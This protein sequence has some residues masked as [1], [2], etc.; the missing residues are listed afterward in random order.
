MAI[1]SR[2]LSACLT[3][4]AGVA[5]GAPMT[6]PPLP[7]GAY[8]EWGTP[9]AWRKTSSQRDQVCLNG[10]W[11][12]RSEPRLA[13]VEVVDTFFTD[14]F[15]NSVPNDWDVAE[16]PGGSL[17]ACPDSV[18]KC[19]GNTS[20]RVEFD[21]P[22]STNFYHITRF[23][24]GIPTGIKLVLRVDVWAELEYGDLHM[25]V[26][27]A[28]GYQLYTARGGAFGSTGGWKTMECEFILPADTDTIKILILRN[29]GS[30]SGC[31]GVVWIDNLRIVK[32]EHPASPGIAPPTDDA[33]GFAKVPGSWKG[34]TYWHVTDRARTN[35]G[36]LRFAWFERKVEVP[37]GWN[38]RKIEVQFERISTDARIYVNGV[39]T[40]ALGYTGGRVDITPRVKPGETFTLSVLVEAR[41]SWVILPTLLTR[42]AKAWQ[43]VLSMTGIVGDAFLCSEPA[44][45]RPRIG[46][47]RI[48][49]SANKGI[50][51]VDVALP[52]PPGAVL[53]DDLTLRCEVRDKGTVVRTFEMAVPANS[54][55]VTCSAPWP[56][57]EKWDIG[58]PRL[59]DLTVS[60]FRNGRVIDE[61]LPIRFGFREFEIRDRFFYLNGVRL[62]LVPCSYWA[63]KGN[64]G[65][66]EAMR[67]WL[68][69]ARNAGYNFV[70]LGETDRPGKPEVASHFLEICDE[71]GIL[72]SVSPLGISHSIYP[73]IEQDEVWGPWTEIVSGRIHRSW[74]HP[75]L[76]MWRMNM[77]LNCYAQ[78]QNPLVLD[79]Q[80]DFL[81]DSASARKEAAMLKSNAF[82]QSLDPTRPT[83]NH[84]CGKTGS[85][86]NLNNYLGW[87]ELQDLR[88]WLRVWA[89]Q[90][91]KPLMMAEQA[92]PYPGDFQMRDPSNWWTNEP[93][94]TEYGAILLG[95]R[96]YVLEEEDYVDYEARCWNA[97]QKKWGSSYGYF[98]FNFPPIL[99]ECSARYYEAMLPAWRT[100]GISG[101][102]NAWENTWRRLVKRQPDTSSRALPESVP[103]DTDWAHLQQPGFSADAWQYASGGGGE[104]RCLFDL[105]RPEESEY[106]EPTLRATVMPALIAP[107]YAYIGGPG[108]DWFTQDHAFYSGEKIAK[109][110]ILLNDTRGVRTFTVHWQACQG[111]RMLAEG[112]ETATVAPAESA[113][114]QFHFTAP[115]VAV[116]SPVRITARVNMGNET[117]AVKPMELQI[118]PR[119]PRPEALPSGWVL[120][121][122]VGK[123]RKALQTAGLDIPGT[124][125]ETAL[126][127]DLKVLVIG[128][129]CLEA[130]AGSVLFTDLTGKM[131]N[132]LQVLVFEQDAAG[133]NKIFGLRSF[134][135]GVRRVWIRD[136]DNSILNGLTNIDLTD[137]RGK[138]TLGA[139]D[140]P[141][142]SLDASQREKRVWRCSQQGVVAS[143]V[144]EKPHIAGFRTLVDTG[145]DLRYTALWTVEEG[146]GRLLFCQLDVTDRLGLDPA[147]D[148]LMRNLVSA[149]RGYRPN[150]R[151]SACRVAETASVPLAQV[152]FGAAACPI[153]AAGTVLVLSRGCDDWLQNHGTEI[154]AYLAAGGKILAAG[155]DSRSSENLV[156]NTGAGFAVAG[157]TCWLNPLVS[158]VPAAFA[159]ISPASIHWRRKTD[160]M[161]VSSVPAGGWRSPSGVLASIPVGSGE[162]IWIAADPADFDPSTRPDLV[163]TRVNSERLCSLV[164]ANLGVAV[165]RSW[166]ACLEPG[167]APAAEEDLYTDKRLVRDDPY[168]YMRW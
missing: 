2:S 137:W 91:N 152:P 77:N 145:F 67:H 60:L 133:L 22:K 84:A 140:G 83:Y 20:M 141:P 97:G 86:Y 128:C 69:G 163:F 164:L 95:E 104:I 36:A 117:P 147:A 98:C 102:V 125:G 28:R 75:S 43:A 149:I 70:Y 76:V 159:G 109:S 122:P 29:Y 150:P 47:C 100:W 7:D 131:G 14:D 155:L 32:V 24:P 119:L 118:H 9:S 92:T 27:D 4:L 108:E 5:L 19:E 85:V 139:L 58:A 44:A 114:I 154:P 136:T 26:Q 78:D 72:A 45:D 134:T 13:P 56:D 129:Q 37:S 40:G 156:R 8:A 146:A 41:D 88:E 90:G 153:P 80:M 103:L 50:L 112:E 94:M 160:T 10:L 135:P 53:P 33:W 111:D 144:V 120:F 93:V 21:V 34:R 113:R 110:V 16:V 142:E 126:P 124:D 30:L 107:L 106:F 167:A 57:A 66:K 64:W 151:R 127:P 46:D 101:G 52:A 168:A 17:Q 39:E 68:T 123:T 6:E 73:R 12:F 165:G 49:T 38:G 31:K 99:D 157:N 132:G 79:A 63:F 59:Y 48:E 82:V 81:P 35:P 61:S 105:G 116:Q 121:D 65:T 138:T 15:E 89:A 71:I 11:Q 74:N 62:N 42:P 3:V 162:I 25:E 51:A 54:A 87:P 1:F 130:A 158:P 96:S 161:T 115:D 166:S 55:R 148:I 143:A 23:V 18:R